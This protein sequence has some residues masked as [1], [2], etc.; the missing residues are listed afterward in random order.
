MFPSV[1]STI[2]TALRLLAATGLAAAIGL[3]REA[4][5]HSAGLRTH[6]L[7][8]LGACLL[9]V[10][11]IGMA[12]SQY[13]PA[14]IA[15]GIVTGIGFIGAGAIMREGASVKG[16]TTAASIWVVAAIGIAAGM[17]WWDG[18]C[19]ATLLALCSLLVLRWLEAW[20]EQRR[21]LLVVTCW[22]GPAIEPVLEQALTKAESAVRR[23]RWV[24]NRPDGTARAYVTYD[25]PRKA[26]A[27]M[28]ALA[29]LPFVISVV[30]AHHAPRRHLPQ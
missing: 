27:L 28:V 25:R 15:A 18:A 4:H 12:G 7:V 23:V 14:R 29:A 16:L 11:S 26:S 5:G 24:R 1:P 30:P 21:G 19:L 22:E 9:T 10:A 3:E 6:I 2:E 17:G 8:G 20:V 13:D